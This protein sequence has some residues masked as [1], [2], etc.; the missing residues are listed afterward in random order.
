MVDF[1]H[2]ILSIGL[3]ASLFTACSL[4]PPSAV[5]TSTLRPLLS[6]PSDLVGPSA[7]IT[8]QSASAFPVL[9]RGPIVPPT[10]AVQRSD[11]PPIGLRQNGDG[12]ITLR[13]DVRSSSLLH[14]LDPS[15]IDPAV[16]PFLYPSCDAR[17]PR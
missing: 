3:A 7:P 14:G 1:A 8:S 17:F 13:S 6:T 11:A 2:R 16:L 4:L 15:L 9:R 12:S 5:P 10:P